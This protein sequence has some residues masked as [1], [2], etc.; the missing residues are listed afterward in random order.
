MAYNTRM[1]EPHVRL[2]TRKGCHLCE[3]AEAVL[4]R[5]GLRPE[6]VDVDQQPALLPEFGDW[7]PVV[8]IDGVVRFRGR[9]DELLLRRI[10]TQS[11]QNAA[12]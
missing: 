1:G 2:Y 8:E 11:E 5:H 6:R 7:V 10:L 4:L 12:E 3:V 9:V